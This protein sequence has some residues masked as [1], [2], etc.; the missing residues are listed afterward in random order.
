MTRMMQVVVLC[1]VGCGL[2]S[3]RAAGAITYVDA[4]LANTTIDGA[5]AQAGVNYSTSYS[6]VTDD[7]WGWR[8]NLT[9]VNGDGIWVTDG[10]EG[11]GEDDRE[12]TA[13]LAVEITFPEAGV[14]DISS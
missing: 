13:D 2:M 8:T 9:T 7:L 11:A 10:G 4:E 12:S 14:Y 6:D 5:A 3:G 1:V